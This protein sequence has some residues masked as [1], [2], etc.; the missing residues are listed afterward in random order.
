MLAPFPAQSASG[1]GTKRDDATE[2]AFVGIWEQETN[3]QLTER[4]L[5]VVCPRT[6][7]YRNESLS[8]IIVLC[9]SR[10][11]PPIKALSTATPTEPQAS[12]RGRCKNP[13]E[14]A[15][16]AQ[17]TRRSRKRNKPKARLRH[18]AAIYDSRQIISIRN[19]LREQDR[20]PHIRLAF[21][22]MSHANGQLFNV[23]T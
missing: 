11:A 3:K 21:L 19:E 15:T 17:K 10:M 4:S 7:F 13:M 14:S 2:P 8:H 23:Q 12:I 22:L 18:Q 1:N 20:C 9:V 6:R 16:E 5:C